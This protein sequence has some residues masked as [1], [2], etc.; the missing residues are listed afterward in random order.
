MKFLSQIALAI[1]LLSVSFFYGQ[2]VANEPQKKVFSA[3]LFGKSVFQGEKAWGNIAG[4]MTSFSPTINWGKEYGNYNE[5]ELTDF[6]YE[7][8]RIS[9]N[10]RVG[11]QY[12]YNWKVYSKSEAS[13]FS[14]FIGSGVYGRFNSG[15]LDGSVDYYDTF[16]NFSAGISFIP[17][18]NMKIGERL[19]LDLN[20]PLSIYEHQ[21]TNGDSRYNGKNYSTNSNWGEFLPNKFTVNVGIAIKF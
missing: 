12:S 16:S 10:F 3:K 21:F 17:R 8:T 20:V 6:G 9:A 1:M 7:K 5:V 2:N 11:A 14:Y 19:Y 13:R 18:V 15:Y 4:V